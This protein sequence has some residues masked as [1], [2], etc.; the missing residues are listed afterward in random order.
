MDE[1]PDSKLA[2]VR[3]KQEISAVI[4]MGSSAAVR[5]R[6]T[7]R[8]QPRARPLQFGSTPHRTSYGDP[9]PAIGLN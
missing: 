8:G 2:R 6:R 4:F 9:Q 1:Q 3:V 7:Y 5:E